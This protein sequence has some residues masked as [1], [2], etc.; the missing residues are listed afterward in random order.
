MSHGDYADPIPAHIPC[1]Q[2]LPGTV[3][4]RMHVGIAA[5]QLYRAMLDSPHDITLEGLQQLTGITVGEA[6][7]ALMDACHVM[8]DC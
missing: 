5:G 1:Q 4:R 6:L 3:Q 7:F 2:A 8:L